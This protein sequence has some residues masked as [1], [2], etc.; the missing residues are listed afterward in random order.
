MGNRDKIEIKSSKFQIFKKKVSY[1]GRSIS[2]EGYIADSDDISA[3][4]GKIKKRPKTIRKVMCILGL[5][6]YF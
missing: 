3:V 2:R 1:L 6:G 4:Q 5:I